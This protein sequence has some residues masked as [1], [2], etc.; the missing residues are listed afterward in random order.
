MSWRFPRQL[1]F[2]LGIGHVIRSIIP[3]EVRID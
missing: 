3:E 2:R 1:F